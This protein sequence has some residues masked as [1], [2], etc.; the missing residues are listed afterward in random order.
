[1]H[2]GASLDL[3]F[4]ESVEEFVEFLDTQGLSH[5]EIRRGY[6]DVAADAPTPATLRD[7]A[8][9]YNVTYTFHAPHVDSN[10]GNLNEALRRGTVASVVETLDDAALAGAGAVVV[11]G[12]DVPKRY[13]DRAQVHSR[14]QAVR[15]LRECAHHADDVGVP[16]C[17]ENQRERASRRRHTATPDRLAALVDDVGVDSPYFGITLDVGHAKATGFDYRELVDRFGDRIVVAHLHDN[18]GTGDDHDPLPSFRA[19]ASEIGAEYNV[20]EMKSLADIERCVR[21]AAVD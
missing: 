18:D 3:R 12:G 7:I 15:S 4:D 20:L 5:V 21:G 11:H 19:V 1:M 16:L 9:S 8:E 6:L 17:L 13:P 2:Y 10:L 14:E